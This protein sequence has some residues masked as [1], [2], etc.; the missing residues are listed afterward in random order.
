MNHSKAPNH[1]M[2]AVMMLDRDICGGRHAP[3]SYSGGNTQDFWSGGDPQASRAKKPAP[4]PARGRE[5]TKLGCTSVQGYR[6]KQIFP[7]GGWRVN[8]SALDQNK[9]SLARL[10]SDVPVEGAT[11]LLSC[12]RQPNKGLLSFRAPCKMETRTQQHR[13]AKGAEGTG[14]QKG[15]S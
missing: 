10:F 6:G 7:G 8:R 15:W 5:H 1:W 3:N 14:M 12:K 13:R 11:L 9:H 2:Q 4:R